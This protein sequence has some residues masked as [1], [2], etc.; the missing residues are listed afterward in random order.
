MNNV[1]NRTFKANGCISMFFKKEINFSGF[2]GDSMVKESACQCRRPKFD[3]W[4]SK[5]PWRSKWQPT[6]GFLPVKSHAQRSLVGYS[7]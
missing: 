1:Y 4:V 5:I 2:P 6:P 3:P 7:P